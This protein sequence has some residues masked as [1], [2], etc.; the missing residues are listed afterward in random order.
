MS[1]VGDETLILALKEFWFDLRYEAN[2]PQ[3]FDMSLEDFAGYATGL[4]LGMV[5]VFFNL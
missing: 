1:H 5:C 4:I 2:P 3:T